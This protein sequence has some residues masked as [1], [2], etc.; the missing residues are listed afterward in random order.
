MNNFNDP[1]KIKELLERGVESLIS[2]ENLEKRIAAGDK[3]RIKLGIDPTGADMHLGHS[4]VLR[5]LRQFQEMG[6]V[7][8]LI[9]GD[10]TT[11]IGDPSGRSTSRPALT[12][13]QIRDNMKDYIK[14]AAKVIDVEKAEIHYNSEW[15][16]QKPMSFL[17]DLAG[18]FTVARL[19]EREDFQKRLKDG[20]DVSMLE[21]L[22]P[23]LQGYD[24]V[25]VKA[26]VEL[27][28]YDQR[29][30]LLFGRKV[31]RAFGQPEQDV[32]MVPLLIGADGE[33]KMSKSVGNYISID[34]E[35]V[36]MFTQLM[37]VPDAL[38]WN[39]FELLTDVPKNEIE[40]LK[41]D[42]E[43][44]IKHPR[45]AKMELAVKI[46]AFYHG[47][48]ASE[49]AMKEFVL[50]KQ[51]GQLPSDIPTTTIKDKALSIPDLLVALGAASSK[52]EARRLS[53]QGGVKLDGRVKKDWKEVVEI[54]SGMIIQIGKS[55]F[56][57]VA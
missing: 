11:L 54:E 25:A 7:A 15:F 49:K 50:V 29:L 38:M 10:F 18:R 43:K 47:K 16:G 51:A 52:G 23:L 31:Q 19:I 12:A 27:G 14:Q 5:K 21:L 33:K 44:E 46:T 35:P 17:M 36:K 30:N 22:Y 32:M 28:G 48:D 4:V 2:R 9:I 34:E 53:E 13:E 56:F 45:D 37:A 20:F 41:T 8:V 1:Q 26:D 39:Y 6:H 24:S 3:L 55:K 57:K 40:M 42:V